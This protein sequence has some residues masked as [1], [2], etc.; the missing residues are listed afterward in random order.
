LPIILPGANCLWNSF[1][2]RFI[3]ATGEIIGL[4][5]GAF[6]IF[7]VIPQIIKIF[8]TKSARDIS[9]IF[10]IMFVAGGLLWLTYGII[11][12]LAPVIFWNV[13]GITLNS[14][15]LFGKLR[16]MNSENLNGGSDR[17]GK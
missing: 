4:A 12:R 5:A 8:K 17:K 7:S 15:M 3:L 9:L 16:F 2:G 6:T 14:I 1:R 13:I 10:S 11:D